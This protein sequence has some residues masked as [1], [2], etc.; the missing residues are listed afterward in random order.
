MHRARRQ[1]RILGRLADRNQLGIQPRHLGLKIGDSPLVMIDH[2]AQK[3]LELDRQSGDL[4]RRNRQL[5]QRHANGVANFA[6]RAKPNFAQPDTPGR[7]R[8]P[9]V[10]TP[11]PS[12]ALGLFCHVARFLVC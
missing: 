5:R 11:L 12:P 1:R 3:H 4:L 7:E 9:R 8:L 10:S 2:R 6:N